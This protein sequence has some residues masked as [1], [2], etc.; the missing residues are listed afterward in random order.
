MAGETLK[1]K[2]PGT[3]PKTLPRTAQIRN[4]SLCK[5]HQLLLLPPLSLEHQQLGFTAT[6][7]DTKVTSASSLE[8]SRAGKL[9]QHCQEEHGSPMQAYLFTL[10]TSEFNLAGRFLIGMPES[11][12][13]RRLGS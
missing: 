2:L 13:Q 3:V 4:L 8:R 12:L 5:Q 11:Q 9:R 6:V 7:A 1:A 10:L